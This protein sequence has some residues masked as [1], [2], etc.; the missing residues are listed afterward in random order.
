MPVYFTKKAPT[1]YDDWKS[2]TVLTF[3][4]TSELM[5]SQH[6]ALH[7]SP[8]SGYG[9]FYKLVGDTECNIGSISRTALAVNVSNAVDEVVLYSRKPKQEGKNENINRCQSSCS[10]WYEHC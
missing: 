5:C 7:H 10:R 6:T 4:V 3:E 2:N 9:T 1:T 8:T